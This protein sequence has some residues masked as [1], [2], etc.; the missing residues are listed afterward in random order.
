MVQQRLL[1]V[2][3]AVRP[4]GLTAFSFLPRPLRRAPRAQ[5]FVCG[6]IALLASASVAA[7]WN[8]APGANADGDLVWVYLDH[9]VSVDCSPPRACFAKS[10]WVLASV[11]CH[12]RSVA[13]ARVVSMN[14]NGDVVNDVSFDAMQVPRIDPFMARNEI[15]STTRDV[16]GVVCGQSWERD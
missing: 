10:Q 1:G 3:N 7:D 11:R 8:R 4:L 15:R 2:G 14:L 9:P 6:L 13:I 5:H 12:R 16:L